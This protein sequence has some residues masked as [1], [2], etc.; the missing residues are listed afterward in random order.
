[1][2]GTDYREFAPEDIDHLYGKY[3][4]WLPEAMPAW[5]EAGVLP[6]EVGLMLGLHLFG[7]TP[8]ML[9]LVSIGDEPMLDYMRR[10]MAAECA[11]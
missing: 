5:M 6:T 11:E 9:P 8:K 3:G 1:M 10:S 7:L 2:V 4:V